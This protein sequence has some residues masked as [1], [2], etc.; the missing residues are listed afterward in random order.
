M[1]YNGWKNKETWLV[2]IW[3]MDELAM[4]L[5]ENDVWEI[6]SERFE[7][8]IIA[9]ELYPMTCSGFIGDL[10][11]ISFAEIDWHEL[12]DAMNEKLADMKKSA[13]DGTVQ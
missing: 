9:D 11:S 2:S 3:H 13:I 7:G 6:T 8:E 1:G 4:Y 5:E 10:L 12:A